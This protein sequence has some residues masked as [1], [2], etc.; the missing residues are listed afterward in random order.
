MG[1]KTEGLLENKAISKA[2]EAVIVIL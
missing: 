2:I 1:E